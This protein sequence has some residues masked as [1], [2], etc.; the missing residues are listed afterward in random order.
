[1]NLK[2][3]FF[4]LFFVFVSV[5][6]LFCLVLFILFLYFVF[7]TCMKQEAR[8]FF[9]LFLFHSFYYISNSCVPPS[10]KSFTTA[11]K[12]EPPLRVGIGTVSISSSTV[13]TPPR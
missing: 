11:S 2:I 12:P 8:E 3:L 4:C 13:M 5:S 1:M 10:S 9:Y 6:F 7:T